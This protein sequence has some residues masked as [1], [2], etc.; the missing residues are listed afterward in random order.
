MSARL[1]QWNG[2]WALVLPAALVMAVGGFA[3]LMTAINYSFQQ[4]FSGDRY[5]W[6]GLDWYSAIL[7]DGA[8]WQTMGRTALFSVL[9]LILQFGLGLFI[10]RK[11]FHKQGRPELFIAILGLP[12]LAPWIV[13]GFLWRHMMDAE[14]GLLGGLLSAFQVTV[15]L[16]SVAWAWVTILA[17]D[18]W[19]W[20]SL[21]VVLCYAGYLSIPPAYF[22]AAKIDGASGWAVFRHIELPKLRNVLLV[23]G[24]LRLADS[25]MIYIEPFMITRGG[26]QVATTFI[27]QELIKTATQEFNLGEAGAISVVYLLLIVPIAWLLFKAM[28]A[29]HGG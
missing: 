16:N 23:A 15:D 17:M 7:H 10:A 20:T 26:P 6:T 22:H 14:V 1:R 25:L 18:L 28:R 4:S 11:L 5:F 9:T 2:A 12:L 13:V 19:H 27:S 3:P 8:F 24:L 29:G 21:V